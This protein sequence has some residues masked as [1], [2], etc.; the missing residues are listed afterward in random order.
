MWKGRNILVDGH[1]RF[2]IATKHNLPYEVIQ[3]DF[4]SREHA[5]NWIIA[6]QLGRRNLSDNQKKYLMGKRYET[7]KLL[8]KFKGN[9]HVTSGGYQKGTEQKESKRTREMLGE[10][11][12]IGER[13]VRRCAGDEQARYPVDTLAGECSYLSFIGDKRRLVVSRL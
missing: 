1:N 10:E 8:S 12:G 11:Y 3:K 5:L 2:K 9:Q 7:E 4:E 13:T 6:N